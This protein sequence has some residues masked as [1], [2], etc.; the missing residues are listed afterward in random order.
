MRQIYLH[1]LGQTPDSWDKTV[2]R[3]GTAGCSVCPD[4]AGLLQGQEAAYQNLYQVFSRICEEWEGPVDL[5]GLSLGGVLALDYAIQHP[6][7]VRSLVLIAAQYRMPERLLRLQNALFRLMPRSMFQQAGFGKAEFLRLCSSMMK[8][9]F[10]G[11]IQRVACPVLI[12]CGEKDS[13]NKKAAAE[14][15][16][17]LKDAE[18]QI[19]EGAGHEVNVDAP[20]RLAEALQGFYDR[21]EAGRRPGRDFE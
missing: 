2:A 11:S 12:L 18:L 17:R 7:K 10:S 13:A 5:C 16:K 8:L 14:L 9:D 15:A 6:E 20:E 21:I 1:G 4:L 19:I 3:L